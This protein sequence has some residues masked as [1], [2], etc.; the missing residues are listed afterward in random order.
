MRHFLK[1]CILLFS[2]NLFAQSDQIDSL[3]LLKKNNQLQIKSFRDHIKQINKQIGDL[4]RIISS[5][6][7]YKR[8]LIGREEEK[9]GQ[10]SIRINE[11]RKQDSIA[12]ASM[13]NVKWVTNSSNLFYSIMDIPNS[14][15]HPIFMANGKSTLLGVIDFENLF[16]VVVWG[17]G[18]GYIYYSQ[19]N[20][21]QEMVEIRTKIREKK[22][23]QLYKIREKKNR[24][25]G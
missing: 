6:A 12:L 15:G 13:P 21:N 14:E 7:D 8:K 16:W 11:K 23:E 9:K 10:D 4:E 18:L 5:D 1:Y 25:V 19:V 22:L 24:T 17:K 20:E 3:I 2:V